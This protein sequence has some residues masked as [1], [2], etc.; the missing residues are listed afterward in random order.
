[1]TGDKLDTWCPNGPPGLG[2]AG[3]EMTQ[4]SRPLLLL[5]GWGK[6]AVVYPTALSLGA[7]SSGEG[8]APSHA[9]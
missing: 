5:R 6:C 8:P 9:V 1:M 7:G 4:H 2:R 3:P